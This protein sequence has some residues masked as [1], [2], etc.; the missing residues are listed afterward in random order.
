MKWLGTG[1]IFIG[2]KMSEILNLIKENPDVHV[3]DEAAR[4]LSKKIKGDYS[5]VIQTWDGEIPKTKHKKIIMSTSDETHQVP[6]QADDDDVAYI[7]KQ[8]IPMIDPEQPKSI[9]KVNKVS[10]LPLCHLKNVQNLSVPILEREYDWSWMG[11]YDP[12]K[13]T[14]FKTYVDAICEDPNLKKK[15]LWYEGWNNGAGVKEYSDTINNTK[16]MLVPRG[17]GS[18]ESF[19]F[20]EAIMVGSI[21]LVID[22]PEVDFYNVAP[23][24]K[25]GSWHNIS[26]VIHNILE[27]PEEMQF[28]SGQSKNWYNYYCSPRGLAAYM[29]RSLRRAGLDV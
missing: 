14:K 24:I 2:T 5:F 27:R 1:K 9:K 15:V 13:R 19:R 23:C 20:F 18:L 11:Q 25:I 21:P 8:Y 4:I 17:S 28:L 22:Q 26:E 10:A 7:F 6:R 3:Y 16:I 29:H 12:Y